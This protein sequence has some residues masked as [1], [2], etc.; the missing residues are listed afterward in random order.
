MNTP[1]SCELCKNEGTNVCGQCIP[2]P[3]CWMPKEAVKFLEILQPIAELLGR[4]N[5]DYGK[6]FDK[7]REEYGP[8]SFHLR[9]ADKLNRIKQLDANPA[10]V[11]DEAIEDTIRDII[12]YCTLELNFREERKV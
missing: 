12:G 3:R 4:K 6:S 11:K 5:A 7:L 9:I 10:Q 8:V 2:K 1:K